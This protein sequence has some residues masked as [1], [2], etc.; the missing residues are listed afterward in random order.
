MK[1]K[2]LIAAIVFSLALPAAAQ[3]RTIAQAHELSLG[4]IRLP[5]SEHGTIA[6]RLCASCPMKLTRISA[7]AQW[8]FNG[9]RLSLEDFLIQVAQLADHEEVDATLLHHLKNDQVTKVSVYFP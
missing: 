2:V 5:Q 6:F 3:L 8:F 7:D 9:S 4:D 1:I